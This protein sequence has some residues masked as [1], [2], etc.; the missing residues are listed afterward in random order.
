MLLQK[1][2]LQEKAL[3][4]CLENQSCDRRKMGLRNGISLGKRK[5]HIRIGNKF[6]CVEGVKHVDFLRLLW[7]L[8]DKQMRSYQENM[9]KE[10]KIG[11]EA[12]RWARAK[13]FNSNMTS[14]GTTRSVECD[15]TMTR[16]RGW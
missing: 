6:D 11:K 8:A 13:V 15:L 12:F 9:G 3:D 16:A 4:F 10:D 7:V 1:K 2:A 14:V 5:K